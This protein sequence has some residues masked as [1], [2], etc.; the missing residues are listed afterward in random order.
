[1]NNRYLMIGLAKAP[2]AMSRLINKID[3]DRYDEAPDPDRFSVRE[4][5]AHLADW[6]PIFLT[7]LQAAV[8]NPGSSIPDIDEGEMAI[9]GDYRSRDPRAEAERFAQ[10]RREVIKYLDSIPKEKW[11]NTVVHPERGSMTVYDWANCIVGHDVYHIEH[12]TEYLD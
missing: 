5:I 6:E 11:A 10:G 1:M 9:L 12:F 3:P 7:R 8:D 4:A 2:A